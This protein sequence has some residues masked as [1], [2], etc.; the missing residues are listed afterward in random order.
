MEEDCEIG[1]LSDVAEQH[2][3]SEIHDVNDDDLQCATFVD[4]K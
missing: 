2:D 1:L 3:A 4:E